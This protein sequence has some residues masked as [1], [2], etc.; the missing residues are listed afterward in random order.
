M[1]VSRHPDFKS[2]RTI[3]MMYLGHTR[4]LAADSFSSL[5][6]RK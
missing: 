4:H 3:S 2:F 6:A 1:A 5:V